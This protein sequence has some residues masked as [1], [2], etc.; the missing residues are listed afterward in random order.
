[1]GDSK[2]HPSEFLE[3]TTTAHVTTPRNDPRPDEK[4]SGSNENSHSP[5]HDAS[6]YQHMPRRGSVVETAAQKEHR[7]TFTQ[8]LATLSQKPLA[9]HS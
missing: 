8:A 4:P 1:M 5:T 7:M 6:S 9:G 3:F 2:P